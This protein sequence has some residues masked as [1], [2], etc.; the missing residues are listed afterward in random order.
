MPYFSGSCNIEC[1]GGKEGTVKGSL[2]LGLC[3]KLFKM[4]TSTFGLYRS[5]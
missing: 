1:G 3:L 5:L 2:M 4:L